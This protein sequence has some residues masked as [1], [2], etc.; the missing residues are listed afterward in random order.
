MPSPMDAHHPKIAPFEE[1]GAFKRCVG[2][3]SADL[4]QASVEVCWVW[5][6]NYFNG[7]EP[8]KFAYVP[9]RRVLFPRDFGRRRMGGDYYIPGMD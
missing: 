1:N 4:H 3:E 5:G 6:R 8:T 7:F 9:S 2:G